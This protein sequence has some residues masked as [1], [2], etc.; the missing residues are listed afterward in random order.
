MAAEIAR[1]LGYDCGRFHLSASP[2]LNIALRAKKLDEIAL[3]FVTRHP[4]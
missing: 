3:G 1:K 2:S 4:G